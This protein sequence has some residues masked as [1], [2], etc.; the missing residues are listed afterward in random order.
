MKI[1]MWSGPRNLSTLLMRSF[2][3]REDT[4]VFD[5][6]FYSYYL[7]ETKLDHPMKKEILS[8]Y[9]VKEDEVVNSILEKKDGIYYYKFMTHH[10]LD[11]TNIQWL[12]YGINC[13]LIRHPS[14]VIN[15]YIKKNK[16]T[17]MTDVGFDQMLRLF[18]YVKNN[19]SNKIIVVNSDLLLEDPE[20]YIKKLCQIL[21]IDF[22]PNMMNW[23]KG[24]TKDFGIWHEHWY[25]DIINSTG[26]TKT[27]NIIKKVPQEYENIYM[28]SLEI[29]EN[30]NTHSIRL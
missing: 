22:T 27:K 10:I 21:K 23:S 9:S 28:K 8:Y 6:P 13:F 26:F 12:K 25:H 3:N 24:I 1:F 30:M 29:Y 11:K 5:E 7:H 4:V 15:S 18:N 2:S 20:N 14:K 17:N 19:I 16:L